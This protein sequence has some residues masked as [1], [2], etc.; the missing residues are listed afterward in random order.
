MNDHNLD[1][2]IIDNMEPKPSKTKNVLTIIALL[3]IVFIVGII[4]NQFFDDSSRKNHNT[5]SSSL[6]DDNETEMINPEL[7][8]ANIST[9]KENNEEPKLNEIIEEALNKPVAK[10]EK[11]VESTPAVKEEKSDEE[12]VPQGKEALVAI[13]KA[14]EESVTTEVEPASQ[15]VPETP[16]IDVNTKIEQAPEPVKAVVPVA[17]IAEK[18]VAQKST[19]A[20]TTPTHSSIKYYIQVGSF[21]Q[22]PSKR[23]LKRIKDSGFNYVI[24]P[25]SSKGIKKLLIGPYTDRSSAVNALVRVR[26]RINKSAFVIKR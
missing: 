17:K 19:K 14:V 25:A 5:S 11:E 1:D 10:A 13:P 12:K 9:D 2:L 4:L 18:P 6:Y 15:K 3:I 26:D 8:L 22:T 24:T 23:F 7:R 21:S 20:P 16:V